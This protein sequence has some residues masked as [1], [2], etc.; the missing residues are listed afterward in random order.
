MTLPWL[1][2]FLI[3]LVILGVALVLY[4]RFVTGSSVHQYFQKKRHRRERAFWED[5]LRQ[6]L[7]MEQ[8][9]RIVSTES[10]AG[11]LGR[12]VHE[13]RHVLGRMSEHDLITEGSQRVRLTKDGKRWALHVLRAHRLWES[14]LADE[15][16]LPMSR[17]HHQAEA[18][19]HHLS[20]SD[21]AA[22]DAHLGH[23]VED[24]HGD[25]IPTA[26]G[27]L[28]HPR[29]TA[30]SQWEGGEH[31][32]VVH[33]EDEPQDVFNQLLSKGIRPGLSLRLG[34]MTPQSVS[35]WIDGSNVTLEPA[36][37]PNVEVVE[38]T[39]ML[40]TDPRVSRLSQLPTGE[41]AEILTLSEAIRGFSRRRLLD[42]GVTPG[43]RIFPI[44]DNPFGDPRAFRVRGTT[45]GIR[46]EQAHEI[47][48]RRDAA[49][50]S[51]GGGSR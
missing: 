21:L 12:P 42:F 11:T 13:L 7:Q 6:I 28:A 27:E 8:D 25:P 18:A 36:L 2:N 39:E 4:L 46:N 34:E 33:L 15:A 49:V 1:V 9:G 16:R 40:T 26:E 22:L 30:L 23:P 47:W 38:D 24:P 37:L 35:V 19:E 43:T 29:G 41:R 50:R 51:V 10:L 14:F 3:A 20:E 31:V 32:R 44:L 17:L 45:I 5:I 48:V